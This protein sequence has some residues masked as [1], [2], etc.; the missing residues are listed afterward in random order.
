MHHI[1]GDGW[2]AQV[3][4]NDLV[5]IYAALKASKSPVLPDLYLQYKDYAVWQHEVEHEDRSLK[6]SQSFWKHKLEGNLSRIALPTFGNRPEQASSAGQVIR[7]TLP[8]SLSKQIL[9]FA[10]TT[11]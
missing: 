8:I 1:V 10:Q 9:D 6:Q 4:L 2:S 3:I 7:H 5:K 11:R